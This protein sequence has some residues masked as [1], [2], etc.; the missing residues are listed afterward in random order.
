MPAAQIRLGGA[1]A[2]F[3]LGEYAPVI[4][5][6][7]GPGKPSSS[8]GFVLL[9][10]AQ[11]LSGNLPVAVKTFQDAAASFP[12]DPQIYFR[13]ALIFSEGRRDQ[14]QDEQE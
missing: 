2:F 8:A 10:S 5:L 4:D 9:G 14:E 12:N 7:T 3:H 11:A 1:T 6:L 13:L